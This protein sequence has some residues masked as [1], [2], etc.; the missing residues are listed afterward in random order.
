MGVLPN[1]KKLGIT[2]PS[3]CERPFRGDGTKDAKT[4]QSH[5]IESRSKAL[6]IAGFFLTPFTAQ[7]KALGFFKKTEMER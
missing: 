6:I 2:G 7:P 1:A 4:G 3:T 5:K